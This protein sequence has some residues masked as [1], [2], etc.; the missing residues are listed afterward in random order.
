MDGEQGLVGSFELALG[1]QVECASF[2]EANLGLGDEDLQLGDPCCCPLGCLGS[3][4]GEPLSIHGLPAGGL[5]LVPD[6]L[7]SEELGRDVG[8]EVVLWTKG[9]RASSEGCLELRDVDGVVWVRR[10]LL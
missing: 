9:H 5:R 10:V 1:D 6:L 3:L 7:G 2:C 4:G 8:G